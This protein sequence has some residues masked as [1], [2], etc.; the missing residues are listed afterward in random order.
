MRT[1][2]PIHGR[3]DAVT[4]GRP[5]I[6]ASGLRKRFGEK[7]A[8]DGLDLEVPA[9]TVLGLL[10][11]N[12]AG[13][14]TAVSILTTLLQ[15]DGGRAE[16]AG[17]DVATRAAE[18]RARIG[19]TGQTDAIDEILSGRQ[20]LELF[21]RLHHLSP[22]AC[23]RRAAELLE[24]FGLTEAADRQA[25]GYS[26]GMKRRLDLAVSFITAPDVLFLDEPTTGQDPRNRMEVWSV[27]REL[28]AGGTTVLLTTH[29]LDEA[30]QLADAIS[31][32]DRGRVIAEGTPN[33]LKQRLGA[34][35]VDL[36]LR[37]DDG[38]A[39][40]AAILARVS[41]AEPVLDR[42]R[43]SVSAPV[44]DRVA[45]LTEVLQAVQ[46]AG[47]AVEDVAL[48]QPTLDDVFLQL[49]GSRTSDDETAAAEE[50]AA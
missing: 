49:T 39:E 11:P 32:V 47:V 36:V 12:G 6:A 33:A 42:S 4:G 46:A 14:T 27:V 8:L 24:Q 28:V 18:V 38:V 1:V 34:S 20:N 9:G 10:G 30:D 44:H 40:A 41:D 29:Y 23:K 19:L 15:A 16:V 35:Q 45:S 13:K 21:G 26:G 5:A 48:R 43:R 17:L 37:D 22:R 25:K 50:V 7:V 31:V 3:S 2:Y